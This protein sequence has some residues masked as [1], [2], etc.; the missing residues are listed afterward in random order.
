MTGI[1]GG[2]TLFNMFFGFIT[3]IA[4]VVITVFNFFQLIFN[5]QY[6][7]DMWNQSS[8]FANA[9]LVFASVFAFFITLIF[10]YGM[11]EMIK[12]KIV[13]KGDGKEDV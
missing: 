10:I 13:Q 11:A 3:M 9:M 5:R 2:H 12:S 4:A 1:T 7:V 6:L 8:L